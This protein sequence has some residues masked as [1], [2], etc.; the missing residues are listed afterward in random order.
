[1]N[2][3]E[4]QTYHQQSNNRGRIMR[5]NIGTVIKT[6]HIMNKRETQNYRKQSDNRGRITR[7]NIGLMLR[8]MLG[9]E[10]RVRRFIS[11]SIATNLQRGEMQYK[12]K[13]SIRIVWND[14]TIFMH[15]QIKAK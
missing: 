1:M 15:K 7:Y 9:T 12:S 8:L 4:T 5:Y 14:V 13:Y 11:G 6:Q 3:R 2:K 10:S